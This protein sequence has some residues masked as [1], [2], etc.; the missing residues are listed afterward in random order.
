MIG[1]G[2]VDGVVDGMLDWGCSE[3]MGEVG[4]GWPLEIEVISHHI[5]N[6][7]TNTFGDWVGLFGSD[8]TGNEAGTVLLDI[9]R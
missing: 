1:P 3:M 6:D 9:G 7:G 4:I 2:C 5:W 8:F